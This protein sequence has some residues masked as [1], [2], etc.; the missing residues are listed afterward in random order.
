MVLL[1]ILGALVAFVLGGLL[2]FWSSLA[3]SASF[4]A[5]VVATHGNTEIPSSKEQVWLVNQAFYILQVTGAFVIITGFLFLWN[6][7]DYLLVLK[8]KE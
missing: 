6:A 7:A 3:S 4:A 8:S 5:T 2:F 1:N